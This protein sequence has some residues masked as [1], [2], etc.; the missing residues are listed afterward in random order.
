L[1]HENLCARGGRNLL[2]IVASPP[3]DQTDVAIRDLNRATWQPEWRLLSNMNNRVVWFAVLPNDLFNS[4]FGLKIPI[5]LA[6]NKNIPDIGALNW[7]FSNLNFRTRVLLKLP[8]RFT[9]FANDEAN[10]VIWHRDDVCIVAWRPI[11]GHHAFVKLLLLH[12]LNLLGLWRVLVKLLGDD[13]LLVTNLLSRFVV[14]RDY[15]LDCDLGARHAVLV[16][17]NQQYVLLVIVVGLWHR[18]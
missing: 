7:F 17:S 12:V 2:Q 18:A 16:V 5:M 8:D 9:L 4:L 13:Q 10:N 14:G 3:D 6:L 11:R 1:R 15:S